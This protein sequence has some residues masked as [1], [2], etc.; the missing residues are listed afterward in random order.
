MENKE[1]KR[2]LVIDLLFNGLLPWGGYVFL[3]SQ[4]GW[5]DYHALLVVTV[6]PGFFALVGIV[7][8]GRP[9]LVATVSLV[10]ILLSLALAA[11]SDDPRVLQ[12]R[13]SYITL[14]M[15]VVFIGSSMVGRPIL[16]LLAKHQ[17]K[18]SPHAGVLDQPQRKFLLSRVN[19]VWGWSFILEFGAKL[20]MIEHLEISQVLALS[21]VMFYGVT[22]ITFGWTVWWLKRRTRLM[23]EEISQQ[24]ALASQ[25]M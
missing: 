16:W 23:H 4:Y 17:A 1:Q 3:Q 19:A 11:A 2:A 22:A 10:T 6:I 15:G 12:I 25:E 18:L 7:R 14:I 8:K 21:P 9:D 13:E 24:A 5:S 20:W